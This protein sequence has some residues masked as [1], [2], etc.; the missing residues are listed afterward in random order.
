MRIGDDKSKHLTGARS[1]W[2]LCFEATTGE[3]KNGATR[4]GL[5]REHF[6]E[7]ALTEAQRERAS[8]TQLGGAERDSN[9]RLNWI[10]WCG[11]ERRHVGRRD[12]A[13][14]QRNARTTTRVS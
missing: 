6:G 2:Q 8:I 5:H 10:S 14:R 7:Q 1:G 11:W 3:R 12:L 4:L 9:E 13:G